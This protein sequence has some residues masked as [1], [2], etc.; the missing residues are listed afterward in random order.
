MGGKERERGGW[1]R[2]R[3]HSGRQIG[4]LPDIETR[5][6]DA[7][8]WKCSPTISWADSRDVG[9]SRRLRRGWDGVSLIA[10]GTM[11][12]LGW[13]R[14]RSY[15]NRHTSLGWGV[16]EKVVWNRAVH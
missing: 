10:T 14:R 15:R 3:R 7:R 5:S 2:K 13:R 4:F 8:T 6:E 9:W 1:P 11:N 16:D 12:H